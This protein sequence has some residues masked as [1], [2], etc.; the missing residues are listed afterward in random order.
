MPHLFKQFCRLDKSRR[1]AQGGAGIGL[2]IARALIEGIGLLYLGSL[3]DP[4]TAL[5]S[6]FTPRRAVWCATRGKRQRNLGVLKLTTGAECVDVHR[7][8]HHAWDEQDPQ[9]P[10]VQAA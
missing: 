1:R 7:L 8:R 9:M 5:R 6:R 10:P 4:A 2:T 3:Q